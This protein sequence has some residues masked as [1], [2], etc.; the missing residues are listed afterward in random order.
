MWWQCPGYGHQLHGNLQDKPNRSRYVLHVQCAR[1]W[2]NIQVIISWWSRWRWLK[3]IV[4]CFIR[5]SK[6]S[7][8]VARLQKQNVLDSFERLVH[9]HEDNGGNHDNYL[10]WWLCLQD[11]HDNLENPQSS[12]PSRQLGGTWS[13][14]PTR[15]RWQSF[16]ESNIII[17]IINHNNPW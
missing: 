4:W 13:R 16:L 10:F 9:D 1:C 5:E 11:H 7:A 8:S 15:N 12:D 14:T 6:F 3:K 17:E 2:G